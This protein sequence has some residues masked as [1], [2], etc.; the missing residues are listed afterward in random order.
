MMRALGSAALVGVSLLVLGI[1][2]RIRGGPGTLLLGAIVVVAILAMNAFL[3]RRLLWRGTPQQ[4]L[5]RPEVQ[6]I[7]RRFPRRTL[8][9]LGSAFGVLL[10]LVLSISHRRRMELPEAVPPVEAPNAP[11]GFDVA[12][13]GP[14]GND[15]LYRS[16]VTVPPG[17]ALTLATVLCSNQVVLK[18]GPPNGVAVLMAPQ[19]QPVQALLSWRLLGNTTFADGAPLQLS[20]NIAGPQAGDKSFQIVPPEPISIDWAAEPP[21][22]WPPQNGHTRFLLVKGLAANPG[23]TGEPPAEW[24]VGIEARV[25]PIPENVLRDLKSPVVNFGSNLFSVIEDAPAP[26]PGTPG[27][28]P[29]IPEAKLQEYKAICNLLLSLS[30][31]EKDLRVTV[32][33]A[34]PLVKDVQTQIASNQAIK[35]RL[36]SENPGL[37]NMQAAQTQNPAPEK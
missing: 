5:L 1:F 28:A 21:R 27:L 14:P 18:P 36:E 32:G 35:L 7:L 20:L 24:A 9:L 33:T 17:Y 34:H 25:D 31:Y 8:W 13:G 12:P 30:S 19:G 16:V 3:L 2:L 10:L 11:L 37:A 15:R 26:A 23:A 6:A 4:T 22:L 29:V